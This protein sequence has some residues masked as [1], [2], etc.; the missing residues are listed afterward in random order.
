MRTV[1]AVVGSRVAAFELGILC[2][3]FGLD[4][5]DDGLPSYGF[6]VCGVR[7]GPVPTTSG[8]DVTVRGLD[9][10]AAADLV[11]AVRSRLTA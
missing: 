1:A 3:V 7:P 5:S 4:R 10:V 9:E 2:Q 11:A 8:F 6:A